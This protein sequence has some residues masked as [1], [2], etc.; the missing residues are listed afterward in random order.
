MGSTPDEPNGN[1]P[2]VSGVLTIVRP[3]VALLCLALL[4]TAAGAGSAP[5][6]PPGAE[7]EVERAAH[8][9]TL[10]PDGRVLV[11]GGIRTGEAALASAELY[12]PEQR[13]FIPAGEMTGLRVGHTATLLRDG[14]VLIVGGWDDERQLRT[15]ELYDPATGRFARDRLTDGASCRRRGDAPA[16]R[17][18]ASCWRG[19]HQHRQRL[20]QRRRVRPENGEVL[21]H[22][23]DA[24]AAG[25]PHGYEVAGRPSAPGG[26]HLER[27]RLTGG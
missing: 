21:P 11:A 6:L 19:R 22:G 17:P 8:T 1:R 12:D 3:A 14:R 13:S 4:P 16:R 25:R 10:L 24:R 15:A 18:G 9:A 26:W 20:R 27:A 5:V 23:D 7:M 2:A